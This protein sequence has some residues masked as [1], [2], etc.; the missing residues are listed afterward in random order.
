[1]PA[2]L[3]K[4]Y[5][6]FKRRKESAFTGND[7]AQSVLEEAMKRGDS[8]ITEEIEDMI[9]DLFFSINENKCNCNRECSVC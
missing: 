1:M 2:R 5:Q 4:K 7:A 9:I 6:V 8:E 3:R